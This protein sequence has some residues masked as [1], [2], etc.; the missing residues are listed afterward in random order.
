[1]A[2]AG[3]QLLQQAFQDPVVCKIPT[4]DE[5]MPTTAEDSERDSRYAEVVR[6]NSNGTIPMMYDGFCQDRRNRTGFQT[7]WGIERGTMVRD[8]LHL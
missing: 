3:S 1:M 2:F 8:L 6:L 7:T 4:E 5:E